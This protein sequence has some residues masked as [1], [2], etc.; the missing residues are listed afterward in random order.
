MQASTSLVSRLVGHDGGQMMEFLNITM[1]PTQ[2]TH[3]ITGNF[4]L[5]KQLSGH[6]QLLLL[7][8][9]ARVT[10]SVKP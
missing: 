9:D 6:N 8:P 7:I 1:N 3:I 2:I 10:N 5:S 4:W